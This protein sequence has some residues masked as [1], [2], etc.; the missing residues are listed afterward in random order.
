MFLAKNLTYQLFGSTWEVLILKTI[1]I[2]EVFSRVTDDDSDFPIF[3]K[4]IKL[5][6]MKYFRNRI[7]LSSL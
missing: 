4:Y 1:E 3:N 5:I 2:F 6:K 7:L